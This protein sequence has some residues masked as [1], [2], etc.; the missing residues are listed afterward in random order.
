MSE[1]KDKFINTYIKELKD[2]LSL[3]NISAA[4][5]ITKVV[6]SAKTGA[7]KEDRDAINQIRDEL[8]AIVGQMPKINL[9]RK[10]VSSFKLRTGQPVGLTATLR[11]ERMYD[12]VSKLINV[13]LPRVRDFKGLKRSAFDGRGNYSIGISEHII[14][15]E[16]KYEGGTKVFGFQVNITTTAKDDRQAE[17]L[18]TKLGFPFEKNN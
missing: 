12:F 14:M 9:S 2:D 1:L 11:G 10:S 13:A 16:S 5:R 18:L 3:D 4:P 15:P 8:A 7:I 6:V 17:A